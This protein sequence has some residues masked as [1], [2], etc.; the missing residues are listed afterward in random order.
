MA[1][2]LLI[3]NGGRSVIQ[4]SIDF[5]YYVLSRHFFFLSLQ[6]SGYLVHWRMITQ[7]YFH[8]Q[9]VSNFVCS[10][11]KE[12]LI[13]FEVRV[14]FFSLI[15]TYSNLWELNIHCQTLCKIAWHWITLFL[16]SQHTDTN[17]FAHNSLLIL[18]I[19]FCHE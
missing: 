12:I 5:L 2:Y 18:T 1:S 4:Y 13:F 7:A 10:N 19:V 6:I 17:N 11:G 15:L 9:T 16:K 8:C 14:I 3:S